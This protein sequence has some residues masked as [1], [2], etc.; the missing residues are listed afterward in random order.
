[1][2]SYE[3]LFEIGASFDAFVATGLAPE[4]ATV[5][6]AR[7]AL[8]VKGLSPQTRQR[9]AAIKG[10]YYLLAAG[11]M[12]CPDCQLNLAALDALCQAQ[13]LV[14][15]A[16]I[17]KARAEQALRDRLALAKVSIPLVVVLDAEYKPIGLFIEQPQA[18]LAGGAE[19]LSAYKAGDYLEATIGDVLSL[20]E[21]A[22]AP[23]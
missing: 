19:V 21:D 1:M 14:S 3:Q 18:V 12:W 9:L 13:P 16:V 8:G 2:A 5:E 17:T 6:R 7:N 20:I 15:L 4:V 23:R 10:R 11:E 22:Q